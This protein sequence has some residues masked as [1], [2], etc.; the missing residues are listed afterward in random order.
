MGSR[1]Q[2]EKGINSAK[3]PIGKRL[4]RVAEHFTRTSA[5]IAVR[6]TKL[7]LLWN[8]LMPLLPMFFVPSVPTLERASFPP[9]SPPPP[10]KFSPF[11]RQSCFP[12]GQTPFF[13]KPPTHTH[14][15]A[16]SFIQKNG[17][18]FAVEISCVRGGNSFRG[19]C[20]TCVSCNTINP[21]LLNGVIN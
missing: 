13:S 18:R 7:P 8:L 12:L 17:R 21:A 11:R 4:G 6:F 2:R 20:M 16:A 14:T 3:Q 9:F 1:H 5:T 19:R 10:E 15:S